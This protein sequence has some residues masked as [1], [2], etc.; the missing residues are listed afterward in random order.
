VYRVSFVYNKRTIEIELT[1]TDTNAN[2]GFVVEQEGGLVTLEDG[3]IR[4]LLAQ[5]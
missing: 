5:R 2:G 4:V 3:W 1:L